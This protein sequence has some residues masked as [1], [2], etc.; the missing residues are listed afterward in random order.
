MNQSKSWQ[1]G[2][3]GTFTYWLYDQMR[4]GLNRGLVRNLTEMSD[5]NNPWWILDLDLPSLV[6]Y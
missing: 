1:L 3:P 4:Q 2:P 5:E 6:H